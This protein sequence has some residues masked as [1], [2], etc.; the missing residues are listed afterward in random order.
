MGKGLIEFDTSK[1]VRLL[2]DISGESSIEG[3]LGKFM[4]A[5]E[6]S[7]KVRPKVVWMEIWLR[8]GDR[9]ELYLAACGGTLQAGNKKKEM[10]QQMRIPWGAGLIGGIA[11]TGR[12]MFVDHT[13]GHE[14]FQSEFA[15]LKG[16]RVSSF[17]AG[18]IIHRNRV[19]GVMAG[20]CRQP[21]DREARAWMSFFT[22]R[23]GAAIANAQAFEEIQR[24]KAQLQEQ[25]T[26]LQEEV[27]E[28]KAFGD[29]VGEGEALKQIIRQ[30]DLVAPTDAS[31]LITGETGCG[32][33]LVAHEIYKRSSR[34]EGAFVRVNCA[35][36]PRDLY[37]SEFFGHAKG[38]FTGALNERAGRFE[39]ADGGTL[40]LD[41]IG[42]I[43]L[44]LQ[45]KLLRAL[46]EKSYERVGEDRTRRV[47]VRIIAA[48]NRDLKKE[49][50]AGRFREDLY[51][52]INIF[53][54]HVPALRERPQDIPL[55]ARHFIGLSTKELKCP[56]PRLPQEALARLCNYDWPGNV[57]ELR[58]VIERAIILARGGPLRFDLP[59]KHRTVLGEKIQQTLPQGFLAESQL[60][61]MERDNLW[62][63][64]DS[65]NWRIKGAGGAAE[66]LGIKPT[67]LIAR[68]KK[69]GLQKPTRTDTPR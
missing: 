1:A 3:V 61:R 69:M 11:A 28:A 59:E 25:N 57:R 21:I 63:I 42:E 8:A 66:L 54:I 50:E 27:L 37:E 12:N 24:L 49:I 7:P 53:P 62:K 52:R 32:K 39:T 34:K 40:F 17:G 9:D 64:L 58:N 46:Q 5:V 16:D 60:R 68:M 43:P 14:E 15:W 65:A 36:I 2:L 44:E 29:L 45:A 23:I 55:L 18:P 41:E 31:V 51:Y 47:D 26:Y 19:L 35:S 38:S 33:E 6:D 67:T 48:T 20:F 10:R 56:S 4:R 13:D 22:D 30:I